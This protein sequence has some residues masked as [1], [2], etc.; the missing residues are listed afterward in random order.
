MEIVKGF[1]EFKDKSWECMD[2]SKFMLARMIDRYTFEYC[3]LKDE[4]N[5]NMLSEALKYVN[6]DEN[7]IQKIFALLNGKIKTTEDDWYHGIV[8]VNDY[9]SDELVSAIVEYKRNCPN[10]KVDCPIQFTC[11]AIFEKY[12]YTEFNKQWCDDELCY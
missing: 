5:A 6:V 10:V 9:D 7:Y 12:K 3:Q 11:Q 8:S 2:S 4:Y 1:V